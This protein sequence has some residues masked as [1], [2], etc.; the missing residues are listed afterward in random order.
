[1][2]DDLI[3]GHSNLECYKERDNEVELIRFRGKTIFVFV[4]LDV[5]G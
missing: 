1:M 4:D 2:L 5:G 3:T